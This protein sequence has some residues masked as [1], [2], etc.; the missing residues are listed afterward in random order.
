MNAVLAGALNRRHPRWRV[1][2]EQTDVFG[3]RGLR[4]DVLVRL[5]GAPPIV[6]ETEFAPATTVEEDARARL[7][8][9]TKDSGH[10]IEQVVAVRLDAALRRASD[11]PAAVEATRV[12]WCVLSGHRGRSLRWP[13]RGWLG[14]GI[15]DLARAI[16]EVSL[17]ER[18]VAEGL[19]ILEQGVR[20]AAHILRADAAETSRTGLEA[21]ARLLHQEDSEQTSRMAMAIIANAMTFHTTLAGMHGI[22]HLDSLRGASG[23]IL[24]PRLLQ[25]WRDILRINYWPIF[26]IAIDLLLTIR[27]APAL[28]IMDRL[29]DVAH[30]LARIGATSLN[31]LSGRMF[32]RLIVDRKFLAT[33]YTL[34]N[35]AALLAELAVPDLDVDWG[36]ASAVQKL[37]MGDLACGTGTLLLAAYQGVLSRHR[38]AGGDDAKL[39]ARMMERGLVAA[40]I[41]PAA[42]HLTASNLSGT[43]PGITFERTCVYTMPYGRQPQERELPIAIGSLDLLDEGHASMA[44]FGTGQRQA[45]GDREDEGN[46]DARVEI[47]PECLDLAIMNPPFTRPTNH[48]STTVPVPS[49]AGFDTSSDEQRDMSRR[50]NEIGR[51]MG[52]RVGNGNAGLASHFVDLAHAKTKPGGRIALVLPASFAQG[53]SW[54]AARSLIETEYEDI[55]VV[56][57]ATTGNTDLAFSADT[58]MAEVLLVARKRRAGDSATRSTLFANLKRR[59][60]SLLEA[61]DVAR[62]IRQTLRDAER[63]GWLLVGDS[64]VAGSYVRDRLSSTGAV[65]IRNPDLASTMLALTEGGLKLPRRKEALDVPITRLSELGNRG[66][67]DRDLVGRDSQGSPRGPWDM[68]GYAEAETPPT[69][70]ALWAHHAPRE[71]CLVVEPDRAGRVREGCHQAAVGRWKSAASQLHFNRDF[72]IN[73]QSLSA[74]LTPE[75]AIG[76]RAWPSFLLDRAEWETPVVLWANTTL[77]LMSFWWKGSRQHQG[78][79]SMTLSRL[80]ELPVLDPRLLGEGQIRKAQEL[81]AGFRNRPLLPANEAYRDPVRAD[82]DHAVLVRLLGLPEEIEDSLR[83][84]RDQW[85]AEPSVHGGKGTRIRV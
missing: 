16:E 61:T 1:T 49:F 42:T 43:H 56:S 19:T 8:K 59:P 71:R 20:Q 78:R 69:Y 24:R 41:M 14:G 26:K 11:L 67:I 68:V 29:A 53:G 50:L 76:G 79:A 40:D 34:P 25:C 33:F 23:S 45:R 18:L 28:T 85:C 39:H 77:G 73:S 17:S 32:Q 31:D 84:L 7:G 60:K 70:P 63:T 36:D 37:R 10:E 30:E 80:P 55:V 13:D 82:L 65:G 22:P 74:C 6:L 58:G 5:G 51:Y 52:P 54:E 81:F 3:H 48:E 72:R 15:D 44:L 9:L 35:S 27:D 21:T 4:P 2:A 38:H 12:E 83:L 66:P 75:P 57:I 64:S 46:V 62:A 47:P